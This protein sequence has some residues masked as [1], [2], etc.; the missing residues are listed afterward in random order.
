MYLST[1][2]SLV[3][4]RLENAGFKAYAVGG[5][6][7]DFLMSK[8]P[9]DFDITTN[10]LPEKTK[11][12]FSDYTTFDAGISHGTVAVMIEG[13]KFE[14]TTFRSDGPTQDHRHPE[15]VVFTPNLKDDLSRR[16]FT[17]NAMAYGEKEGIVDLFE[18][19]KDLKEKVIRCVGVPEKRFEE[20]A[21]RILRALRFASVLDFEIEKNTRR[22]I[23]LKAGLLSFVS[24]ERV[25]E[26]IKKLLLG[27]GA[28]KI[29][30]EYS[31]VFEI[32]F[33][34]G[35]FEI[36][37]KAIPYASTPLSK[38]AV[39]FYSFP[40]YKEQIS[41]LKLSKE[42]RELLSTS[43][44]LVKEGIEEDEVFLKR[45]VAKYSLKTVSLSTCVHTALFDREKRVL[46]LFEKLL[47]EDEFVTLKTLK[48]TGKDLVD[49]GLP[50]S[51]EVG[52]ILSLLVDDVILGKIK[53]DRDKLLEILPEKI[54]NF[55]KS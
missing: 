53:N 45:L 10:A 44:T 8:T 12:L 24:R 15:R 26:E 29:I 34:K 23:F 48:V 51:K 30:S 52:E 9:V 50:A 54:N 35:N 31:E 37:Q 14:I 55:L 18:G 13:E 6:V 7:R 46:S 11:A 22:A 43:I 27:K 47:T 41:S 16:D 19:E 40:E 42:E 25:A 4:S 17:V 49:L 38:L 21:L 36:S 20:D 32:L 33:Q 5:C 2:A 3:I 1:G 28:G 39:F